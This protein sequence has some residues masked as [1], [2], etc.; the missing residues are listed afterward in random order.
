[1]C[2]CVTSIYTQTL[3]GK[4]GKRRSNWEAAEQKK[5]KVK[6]FQFCNPLAKF[7]GD[8]SSDADEISICWH[9]LRVLQGEWFGLSFWLNLSKKHLEF[10]HYSIKCEKYFMWQMYLSKLCV[11]LMDWVADLGL[12]PFISG[13][14]F[15]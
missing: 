8:F 2:A 12:S 15:N 4:I 5:N 11:K 9:A 3:T 10:C 7:R 13:L 6:R 1:M 14:C